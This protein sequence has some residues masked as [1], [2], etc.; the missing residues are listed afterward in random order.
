MDEKGQEFCEMKRDKGKC[1]NFMDDCQ[2]TCG[3]CSLTNGTTASP[4]PT[5]IT[6][7]FQI[8]VPSQISIPL[9]KIDR[10]DKYTHWNKRIPWIKC[11]EKDTFTSILGKNG[12]KSCFNSI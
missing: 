1:A 10:N 8:N 6:L 5:V 3:E 2:L 4:T 7:H 12:F 11:R 9:G